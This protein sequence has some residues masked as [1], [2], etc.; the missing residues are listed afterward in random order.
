MKNTKSFSLF[1]VFS[2]YKDITTLLPSGFQLIVSKYFVDNSRILDYSTMCDYLHI[3]NIVRLIIVTVTKNPNLN[4]THEIV[5]TGRNHSTSTIITNIIVPSNDFFSKYGIEKYII[6]QNIKMKLQTES[7]LP[8]DDSTWKDSR[9]AFV[10]YKFENYSYFEVLTYFKKFNIK[11]SGGVKTRRDDFSTTHLRM[12]YFIICLENCKSFHTVWNSFHNTSILDRKTFLDFSNNK[13]LDEMNKELLSLQQE[14]DQNK[15]IE[16][17]N[18][19]NNFN[20]SPFTTK[21]QTRKYHSS[22]KNNLNLENS[23]ISILTP[24]SE[25]K[26]NFSSTPYLSNNKTNNLSSF[27]ID[28]LKYRNKN[29]SVGLFINNYIYNPLFKYIRQILN[30]TDLKTPQKQFRIEESLTEFWRKEIA[31]LFR[32]KQKL[33]RSEYGIKMISNNIIKLDRDIQDLKNDKRALKGKKY[34][35]LFLL[36][37]NPDIISIVLCNVIPFCIKY[38]NVLDQNIVGL[39][40]K[41]GKEIERVFY[42]SEWFKYKKRNKKDWK[43]KSDKVLN[44][45]YILDL[46]NYEIIISDS[47]DNIVGDIF[48]NKL[49]EYDF[50]TKLRD[51][52]GSLKEDDYFLLGLDLIEFISI[53]SLLFTIENKRIDKETIKRYILPGESLKTNILDIIT[54]DSDL[55]PMINKPESWVI[56]KN[57]KEDKFYIK[58]YGGFISNKH[59]K[60]HYLKNSHKNIGPSRLHNLDIINAINYLSSIKYCINHDLL[61]IIFELLDKNDERITKLIK[62]NLHPQTKDIFE[63]SQDKNKQKE[64]YEI[65]KHNSQYYGDRSVLQTALLFS[66]WCSNVKNSIYFPLFVDWRGRILTNTGFFSYQKGELARSL[67]LFKDGV[68]LNEGGLEALQI[69]TAN[70]FGRDKLSYNKRLDW[71]KDN[72]D[73]IINLDTDFIFEADEPFL[74]LACCLELKGYYDD[75]N[76]F[77]SRLPVYLDATC[78]GLQHLSMMINDINLAKYVNILQSSKDDIPQ[79]VYGFMVDKVNIK[80]KELVEKDRYEYN[81]LL[82]INIIRKFIKRAIMTIPYGATIRGIVNQLKEK[83]FQFYKIVDKKPT[84]KLIDSKYDKSEYG[85]YLNN[86]QINALGTILHDILYD[87]FDSLKELVK[88]LKEMNKKLKKLNLHPIWLTPG[89]LIIEQKYVFTEEKV[90]SSSMLGKRKTISKRVPIKDMIN[91]KKQNEGIV[92]NLVHSFDA[93]NISLLIKELLKNKHNINILT[94]HDCFATNANNVELMTLHVKV[95][96]S[97]LYSNKSFVNDYH[98]FI[99]EYIIKSGFSVINNTV[100]N[101]LTGKKVELPNIPEFENFKDLK[102][103]ILGSQYFI[104]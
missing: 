38:E 60:K 90:L 32:D 35:T 99:I 40:E 7:S 59:N 26:R 94:I 86:K 84:Y 87:T 102:E 6:D 5:Y 51:I 71:V 95:A 72:L 2:S 78:N 42:I 43:D 47:I 56:N 36:M 61:K 48:E 29:N 10:V 63:L 3:F 81:D 79:D 75:P 34:R 30:D 11:I 67:I 13:S 100:Y 64:L 55:I 54:Q 103:N 15:N 91:L 4:H 85:F 20:S 74:F 98:N 12:A 53:K 69:Y 80:I 58:K 49:S 97:M 46:K 31:A 76:N 21:G 89:G 22:S 44:N 33:F 66:K 41:I 39:Y 82:Y 88:Y 28:L 37:S 8:Y 45:Y 77:I 68:K 92:P 70:C 73:K 50:T 101:P 52:I 27:Y 65:L 93:S 16:L 57:K 1:A 25:R 24:H 17:E 14:V 9:P 83:F 23:N 62:I 104:N 96:F 18:N 19:Q